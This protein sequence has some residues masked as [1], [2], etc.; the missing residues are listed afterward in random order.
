MDKKTEA[1]VDNLIA[2]LWQ[3]HLPSLRERIDLLDRVSLE[4]SAGDG[5]AEPARAEALSIAHKLAGNLGMYGY[6]EGS[7][8]ASEM[9]HILKAPTPE[10]L[11]TLA[12]LAKQLR[13][14]LAPNL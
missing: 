14:A 11:L 6:P 13:K 5:L 8:V 7:K 2:E 1:K 12:H 4:A 3:R 9:E 10:N